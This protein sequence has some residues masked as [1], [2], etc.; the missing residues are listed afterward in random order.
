MKLITFA[1]EKD[2]MGH[3]KDIIISI[4]ETI[5]SLIQIIKEK[6]DIAST[7]IQVY[8]DTGKAK[9][10]ILDEDKT[11]EYY[12]YTGG[13]YNDV[14][15]SNEKILLYFDFSTLNNNDPILNCDYYFF[16]YKS[17]YKK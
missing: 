16:N 8:K 1:N 2:Y 4:H 17:S 10:S 9:S 5:Y 14:L 12:G 3:L 11:L 15:K 7:L 13:S 6:T